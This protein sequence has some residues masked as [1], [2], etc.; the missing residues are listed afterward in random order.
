MAKCSSK[1][2][3]KLVNHSS[4]V[5]AQTLKPKNLNPSIFQGVTGPRN[6]QKLFKIVQSKP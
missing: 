4:N 3:I 2:S 5:L 1:K 6:N